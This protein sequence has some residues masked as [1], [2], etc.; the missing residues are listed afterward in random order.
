MAGATDVVAE[1]DE[2]TE[3]EADA[4]HRLV[5]RPCELPNVCAAPL[6]EAGELG[7]ERD[8]DQ[9]QCGRS[10]KTGVS[11]PHRQGLEQAAAVGEDTNDHERNVLG[12][13]GTLGLDDLEHAHPYIHWVPDPQHSS[14]DRDNGGEGKDRIAADPLGDVASTGIA[15]R[16]REIRTRSATARHA[17]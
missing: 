1:E 14:A 10:R 6:E 5:A 17:K 8:V 3:C 4:Q 15:G 2:Q 11:D 9:T 7:S 12:K 13:I 16:P